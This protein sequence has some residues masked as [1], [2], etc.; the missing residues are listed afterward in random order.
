MRIR[1][2]VRFPDTTLALS[3]GAAFRG[4]SARVHK[5]GPDELWS[6]PNT[7]INPDSEEYDG[8]RKGL[9]TASRIFV[10]ADD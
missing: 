2:T 8:S 9:T 1:R 4:G 6:L 3:G 10:N 7:P 5:Y